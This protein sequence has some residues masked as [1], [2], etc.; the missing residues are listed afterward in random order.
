MFAGLEGSLEDR[1]HRPRKKTLYIGQLR[2]LLEDSF[3][4]WRVYNAAMD[5][6]QNGHLKSNTVLTTYVDKVTLL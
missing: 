5:L 1:Y 3:F 2:V 4:P 6:P